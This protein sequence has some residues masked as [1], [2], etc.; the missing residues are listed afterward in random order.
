MRLTPRLCAQHLGWTFKKHWQIQGK[1]IPRD[2]GA[3]NELA[4]FGITVKDAL[5]V[6]SPKKQPIPFEFEKKELPQDNTHPDWHDT[7][8]YTYGDS[9][10]LLEGIQQAQLLTKTIAINGLPKNIEESLNRIDLSSNVNKNVK[11]AIMSSHVFD[12]E[13]V[14]LPKIK[15]L[16]RPAFNLPRDYGISHERRM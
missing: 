5:E 15:L 11:N 9:N 10:V 8:C 3:A 7:P 14:K 12:A 16:D 4:K 1:R 13:Q 6:A 2:T